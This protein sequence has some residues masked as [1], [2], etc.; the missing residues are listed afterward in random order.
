MAHLITY[1]QRS[2][3]PLS[4]DM[5]AASQQRWQVFNVLCYELGGLAFLLGSIFYF[6]ALSAW[7]AVGGW[8]FFGGS[9][10]YLIVTG[11]DFLEVVQYWRLRNSRSFASI[12]EYLASFCYATG[13]LLFAI[14]SLLFLPYLEATAGGAWC[15][16]IGSAMFL[17]GGLV[18]ILQVVEAP[19]LIYMQLFNLTIAL[20]V[21]GSTIFLMAS[22]PYL[23]SVDGDIA[24][25]LHNF[26]ASLF[27][28]GSVLFLVGGIDIFYRK[29]VN[30]QLGTGYH[31]GRLGRVFLADLRDEIH[32]RGNRHY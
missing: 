15:F 25:R 2:A 11:H 18:N 8:L 17:V 28:A 12:I 21:I 20:F 16:I 23:W 5:A 9:C 13:S 29:L 26:D 31:A 19:S 27:V 10:L 22:I 7:L 3:N 14:G 24:R 4:D 32:E 1:R 30:R 6:P